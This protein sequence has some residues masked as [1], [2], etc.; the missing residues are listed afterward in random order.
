MQPPLERS[1]PFTPERAFVVQ[2]GRETA[3]DAGRLVGRVEPVVTGK[4]AQF[5][6]LGALMACV[7]AVLGV[8]EATTRRLGQARLVPTLVTVDGVETPC[9]RSMVPLHCSCGKRRAL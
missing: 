3:V 6:S 2:S 5:T 4:A 8:V 7:I 1:P 9:S